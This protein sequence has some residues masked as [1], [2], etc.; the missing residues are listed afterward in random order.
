MPRP[1]RPISSTPGPA[2]PEGPEWMIQGECLVHVV[3]E[4]GRLHEAAIDREATGLRPMGKERGHLG[5]DRD[6]AAQL[7]RRRRGLQERQG[8]RARGNGHRA[9]GSRSVPGRP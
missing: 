6:V 8:L 9:E 5:D 1:R 7:R 3:E 2:V 4:R